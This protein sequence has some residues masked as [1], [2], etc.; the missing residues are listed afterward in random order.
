[1]T[2]RPPPIIPMDQLPPPQQMTWG[3]LEMVDPPESLDA[4]PGEIFDDTLLTSFTEFM[5]K[6]TVSSNATANA[7]IITFDALNYNPSRGSDVTGHQAQPAFT[8][9]TRTCTF[10]NL[11][12]ALTFQPVKCPGIGCRVLI[13]YRPRT[14]LANT[15]G[16]LPDDP[17]PHRAYTSP[18]SID[19]PYFRGMK[20]EWDL[21]KPITIPFN[22]FVTSVKR[23]M[24]YN[25]NIVTDPNPQVYPPPEIVSGGEV[26]LTVAQRPMPGSIYP[27]TFEINI[28]KSL[29]YFKPEVLTTYYTQTIFAENVFNGFV[30]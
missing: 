19:S 6:V 9:C 16:V 27:E 13:N 24:K 12:P 2:T 25:R 28:F 21:S 7:R 8:L 18:L 30:L 15:T 22:G 1:M 11:T 3:A 5:D 26:T 29:A 20:I 10:A 17:C 4:I 23:P 14:T